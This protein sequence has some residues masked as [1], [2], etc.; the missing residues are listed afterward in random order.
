VK[1]SALKKLQGLLWRDGYESGEVV[2]PLFSDVVPVLK[3]WHRGG[4]K[5]A[6]FSSGS[7]EAQRLFFKYVGIGPEPVRDGEEKKVGDETATDEAV[8][9][10]LQAGDG[11]QVPASKAP[12]ATSIEN[13]NPLFDA[14]FDTVNAGPK[15]EAESYIKIVKELGKEVDECLFLS[16]NVDEVF[17]AEIAGLKALVVDRPGN[18]PISE[19]D[20]KASTMIVS[21]AEIELESELDVVGEEM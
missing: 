19:N 13:L 1:D 20:I 5:L 6:I 11:E 2:T 12:N 14:N 3:E 10:M 18:A 7:V 15:K 17:A 8:L 9:K 16:D 4:V 21:L